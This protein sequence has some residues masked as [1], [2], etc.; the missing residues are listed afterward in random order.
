MK[1]TA[2]TPIITYSS[3][4]RALLCEA[5]LRKDKLWQRSFA[6]AKPTRSPRHARTSAT[7]R[8]LILQSFFEI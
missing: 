3:A 6:E 8:Q 2:N 4:S 1:L 7:F 5:R